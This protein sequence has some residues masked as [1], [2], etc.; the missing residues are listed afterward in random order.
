MNNKNKLFCL[1]LILNFKT[2]S[3][4]VCYFN[5]ERKM[6][7]IPSNINISICSM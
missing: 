7:L 6:Q 1:N 3:H 5:F 4:S 2:F